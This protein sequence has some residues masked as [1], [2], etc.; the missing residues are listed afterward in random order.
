MGRL[1]A[2]V[3]AI[4][5]AS[6][7]ASGCGVKK[8]IHQKALDDLA[9]TQKRLSDTEQDR[10]AK[11]KRI[12]ELE[13]ELSTATADLDQLS[14]KEREK[15]ERIQKLMKDMEA[16]ESELLA[17]R[18]QQEQT[19]KRL[20][21]FREL[22]ERFRALVDTGKLEVAFRNGQMVLK[23]PS[24]VLFA[25]GKAKLSKDGEKALSEVLDVLK[26]FRDR[27]FLIAGHTDNLKVRS[28][29]FKNNWHL[30][31]ARAVS[32]LEFMIEAGFEPKNLGAA[33]YG[34]FDPVAPNDS[35][36]NRQ[37]NRRIEII[38]VPDLSELPNLTADPS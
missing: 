9:A 5:V 10:N 25:S 35:D 36:E 33:G 32:V 38:L 17:L 19:K 27:R 13:D 23:L 31:T 37:L 22:N 11:K 30:S 7:L 26:Q 2:F 12:G 28:R 29:R 8:E 16:T 18:K 21:A 4:F 1:A 34:E 20:D 6:V 3:T 15:R 14:E 24:G